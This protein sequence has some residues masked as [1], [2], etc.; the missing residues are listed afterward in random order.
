MSTMLAAARYSVPC[1]IVPECEFPSDRTFLSSPWAR[2]RSYLL[3]REAARAVALAGA[4]H[5]HLSDLTDAG[6]NEHLA[7]LLPKLR[8]RNWNTEAI[9]EVLGVVREVGSRRL[10]QRAFDEQLFCAFV[11]LRG[12]L[13]EMET[14]EGKTLAAAIASSIVGLAGVPVHVLSSNDYLVDRDARAMKPLYDGLGLSVGVVLESE[15]KFQQRQDAYRCHIT[16]LTPRELAFDYLR[17]RRTLGSAGPLG[18]RVA[19]IGRRLE[20]GLRQRGLHFAVVDEADDVLLDQA[21]TPFILSCELTGDREGV[22]AR[23]ALALARECVSGQDFVER[24]SQNSV[25]LTDRGMAGLIA[26]DRQPGVWTRSEEL[27]E[28]VEMALV[29]TRKLRRDVDY[30]VRDDAIEIVDSST[31]RRVPDQKFGHGLHQILELKEGLDPSAST[32]GALRIAGQSLFRRYQNLSAMT[33]TASESRG[34]FWRVYGLPVICVPLR[35]PS[36]RISRGLKC[37]L[38]DASR[39]AEIF[40]MVEASSAQGR[41]VLVGTGSIEAS[42]RIAALLSERGIDAQILNAADDSEEARIISSAGEPGCVTVTTNMAGR[43]TDIKI[44]SDVANAG[45]LHVVCARV[46]EARRL[47]RQLIGRCARQGDPGS[48]ETILSLGDPDLSDRVPK[49]LLRWIRDRAAGTGQLNPRL[50]QI[51]LWGV[52]TAE[53]KRAEAARRGLLVLESGRVQLLAFAGRSE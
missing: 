47:D 51:L 28:W 26:R 52:Q 37:H 9:A 30:L 39:D 36:V 17:D 35:A 25:L 32:E 40:S 3:S 11:L 5:V 13:A 6:L 20:G 34:E 14:G 46:G 44:S 8:G 15:F 43:G 49:P 10:E 50:A 24:A 22:R 53:E 16:Y 4:R 45:G 38:N 27:H 12:G 33:G 29:A 31:G 41:P 48:F 2:I 1:G 18:R 42:R 19:R 21:R 23:T 7:S